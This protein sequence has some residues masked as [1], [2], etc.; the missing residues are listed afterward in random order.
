M[1]T[2]KRYTLIFF[3]A[4]LMNM[5]QLGIFSSFKLFGVSFDIV[6]IFIICYSLLRED[7]ECV[8]LALICGL[9]R[10]SF[11]PD[12]FGLNTIIYISSAYILCHI[13]KKIYKD[14]ILIPMISTFIAT[15]YKGVLYYGLLFA[16]SIRYDFLSHFLYVVPIEAILNSIV[17]IVVFKM[18]S[19]INRFKCMHQEWKF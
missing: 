5:L 11:Y 2:Y 10:D 17:S 18:V 8:V 19:R 12:V 6:F 4:L 1:Q 9:I 3:L 16:V 15:I 14:A 7:V 13:E